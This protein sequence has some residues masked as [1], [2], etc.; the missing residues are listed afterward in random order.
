[1]KRV[2]VAVEGETEEEFVKQLLSPH[3][4]DLG[5]LVDPIKPWGRGGNINVDRLAPHM[6]KLSWNYDAVTSLVD[7]YR[8]GRLEPGETIDDLTARIDAA[9]GNHSRREPYLTP[10]FAYVQQYELEALL[11]SDPSSFGVVAGLP[12]SALETLGQI[13][14]GYGTPEDINDGA[15]TAPS[16]RVERCFKDHRMRYEKRLHGPA[17]AKAIGLASIREACPR[18]DGWVARLEA[19]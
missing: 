11:F 5:I 8:F 14:G 19:L 9:I 13:A 15:T 7:F 1:M 17:V 2:A 6:A 12:A 3:L 4:A 16:K 10:Q 18:F